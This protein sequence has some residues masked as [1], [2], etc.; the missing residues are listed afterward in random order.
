[1]Q[2]D[3]AILKVENLNI[4][5]I[6]KNSSVKAAKNVNFTLNKSDS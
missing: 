2:Q 4:S 3:E 1:M 5:Y 6:N